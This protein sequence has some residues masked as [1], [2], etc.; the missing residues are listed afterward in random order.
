[1]IIL[2]MDENTS[3]LSLNSPW[4]LI[5]PISEGSREEGS[6]QGRVRAANVAFSF[7]CALVK[8]G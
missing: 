5:A 8:R 1:M 3:G 7:L 4:V 2:Q 6:W